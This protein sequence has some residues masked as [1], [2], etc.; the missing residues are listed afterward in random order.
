MSFAL[1]I[2]KAFARAIAARTW[3]NCTSG[4]RPLAEVG[5]VSLSRDTGEEARA[6]IEGA[7]SHESGTLGQG[8]TT[9]IHCLHSYLQ[10][11]SRGSD[12]G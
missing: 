8:G 10:L 2:S 12:V 1:F 5:S 11:Q 4:K 9:P 6:H 7:L 3:K